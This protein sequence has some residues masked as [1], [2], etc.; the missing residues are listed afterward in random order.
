[1]LLLY[2]YYYYMFIWYVV[3]IYYDTFPNMKGKKPQIHNTYFW[4]FTFIK[5]LYIS[6]NGTNLMKSRQYIF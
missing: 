3:D 5:N 1:M 2:Y 4:K 6:I